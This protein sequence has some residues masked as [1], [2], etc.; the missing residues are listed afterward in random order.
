MQTPPFPREQS[1][2]DQHARDRSHFVS[3]ASLCPVELTAGDS[4]ACCPFSPDR[5]FGISPSNLLRAN[6]DF[7][8]I[9]GPARV[10]GLAEDKNTDD[11]VAEVQTHRTSNYFSNTFQEDVA[12]SRSDSGCHGEY[13]FPGI[14]WVLQFISKGST[15]PF[16]I[17]F[18]EY[19]CFA[20][21]K[22]EI[23]E[24]ISS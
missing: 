12:Q 7:G 11:P 24:N 3:A 21:L 23:E 1:S 18:P 9:T 8:Q 22:E 4:L 13:V 19:F 6:E 14:P 20:I 2:R 16:F 10:Q 5:T 15:L 17:S